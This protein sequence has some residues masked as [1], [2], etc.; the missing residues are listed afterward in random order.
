MSPNL[1]LSCLRRTSPHLNLSYPSDAEDHYSQIHGKLARWLQRARGFQPHGAAG[2]GG[3]WIENVWISHFG[4]LADQARSHGKPLHSVFG[5]YIPLFIPFTDHWRRG[6]YRYPPGLVEDLMDV[7][8]P[9]VAYVTVSQNDEGLTGKDELPMARIPNILVF[10]AGGYGHVPIPLL[11]QPE[12]LHPAGPMATRPWV[13]SYL[14]SLH[15]APGGLREQ[16]A[17]IVQSSKIPSIVTQGL[18]A[19]W[20]AVTRWLPSELEDFASWLAGVPY[21]RGVMAQS[22]VSLCPRGFGRSSYHLAET[23]QM[24][25]VPL[26]VYSDTPWIPYERLFRR[27]LGF[28]C[29]VHDLPGTLKSVTNLSTAELERR[30]HNAAQFGKTHFTQA[31]V[32]KQIGRFLLDPSRS[33]LICR[34]L[35]RTIRDARAA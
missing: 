5:S 24:G 30:E 9:N 34:K 22:R 18:S 23:I 8:R 10:S 3:P 7:L 28:A 14:G 16:M 26:Y 17:N 4:M 29:N 21:W 33:D 20:A 2:Y 31:G 32:M 27:H 12:S 11:K 1:S 19:R 25:R 13:V 6:N 35:P 15:N